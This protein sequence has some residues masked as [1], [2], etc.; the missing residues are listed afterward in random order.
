MIDDFIRQCLI[1]FTESGI[2]KY[3]PRK[4]D[5]PPV[6]NMVTTITGARKAGKTFFTYQIIDT[7]IREKFIESIQKVCYV[8][9]DDDRLLE[10]RAQDLHRIDEIFLELSRSTSND[11][12]LFV[13]DEIH[14]IEGWEYF[15]LRLN[16]NPNWR[17]VVTGSSSQLEGD[18]IGRQLRGKTAT[19]RMLPLSFA[20][21]L[22]FCGITCDKERLSTAKKAELKGAFRR[23]LA[24]GSFPAMPAIPQKQHNE[25][26][27]QYF[28]SIV[29]ADFLDNYKIN[30][31]QS[32]R[33]FL[34][35]LLRKN[36]CPYTHQKESHV[37]A[38]MGHRVIHQD[39]SQWFEWACSAF[40]IEPVTI[41]SSS[42]KKQ[43]Q[44]YRKVYA[45][46]W[47][48][49]NRVSL[50]QESRI[51][52]SLE[53]AVFWHLKRK[54][55]AIT[56]ELIGTQKYEIDFIVSSPGNPPYEA[57]Q[58]CVD[59]SDPATMDREA[60]SLKLL[61]EKYPAI[62]PYI[63]TLNQPASDTKSPYP[64]VEAWRWMLDVQ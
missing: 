56:Y 52:R 9:F 24:E 20:E 37:L 57:I 63:V 61:Q 40:F 60:R 29:A 2:P 36:A 28:N 41:N 47:A 22:D 64:I 58:V 4:V 59:I 7:Y 3:I 5:A 42:I 51:S 43:E 16:R 30:H 13:F 31:P 62:S 15:A 50:F 39:I 49:A 54:N 19:I 12:L 46:D 8:H 35:N 34:R 6:P 38:S 11:R 33:L 17:V 23:Y 53:S 25:I 14:R 1:E 48:L 27:Q 45:V 32:C 55:A 10:L 26:L 21:H 44:N 18:K